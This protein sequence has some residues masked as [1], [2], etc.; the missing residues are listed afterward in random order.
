MRSSTAMV[1]GL[2][3]LYGGRVGAENL[4]TLRHGSFEVTLTEH[5][6]PDKRVRITV[7][8]TGGEPIAVR[9]V[10]TP[11]SNPDRAWISDLDDDGDFEISFV[12]RRLKDHSAHFF[13][14]EFSDGILVERHLPAPPNK[15]G[16]Y[17]D[18][19]FKVERDRIFRTTA[20][21]RNGVG[22]CCPSDWAH[23]EYVYS[24]NTFHLVRAETYP[25][26]EHRG[27]VRG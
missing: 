7:T 27:E 18:F 6:G 1:C 19:E 3:M 9:D 10:A 2:V 23:M 17:I 16:E 20:L 25:S 11:Y 15:F 13:V 5:T 4:T 22:F 24:D 14:F 21:Y 8:P 12:R 26:G